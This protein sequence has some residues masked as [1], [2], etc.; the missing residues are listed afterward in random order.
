MAQLGVPPQRTCTLNWDA[1]QMQQH[2]LMDIDND[3][4]EEIK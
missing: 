3:V 4:T 2:D 1:F